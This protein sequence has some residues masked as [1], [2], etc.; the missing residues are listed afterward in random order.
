MKHLL[1]GT[2]LISL[3]ASPVFAEETHRSKQHDFEVVTVVSG[4][5]YPWGLTFLP[6]GDML[7]TEQEK[8][9]LRIVKNGKLDPRPITGLPDNIYV[10]GQGGLLDV[11]VHPDFEKNQLVYI[12]YSAIDAWLGGT[13]VARAKLNGYELEN[14]EVIFAAEPKTDGISHYGSR[15][16][17]AADGTLFVSLGDRYKYMKNA[18]DPS[19]HLGAIIRINDDGSIPKDNPFVGKKDHRPEIY[20]YGHR[21]SQ[22]LALRPTDQT[23]WMHEHGPRGGDEVN[24]LNKPGANYGWPAI[25]YGIDYSGATISEKTHLPGM[26]QPVIQWT[27]SIAPSGMAFYDGDKFPEWKG[28]IFVGALAKTH[29]RRLEMEGNQVREQEELVKGIGRVRDVVS[30]P[31]GYLYF[32]TDEMD[33]KVYRLEPAE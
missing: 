32:I 29:I 1:A 27:P 8:P 5:E 19:D 23:M 10:A 6:N 21:N 16:V 33:G 12:A 20:S 11:A 17:F 30:G 26:E 28:D 31:D 7:V 22:G 4:I 13:E 3:L 24:I 2:A 25:T 14:L 9:E 15:L 18:Q